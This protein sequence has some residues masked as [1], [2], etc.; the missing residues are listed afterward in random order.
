MDDFGGRTNS[1]GRLTSEI[2]SPTSVRLADLKSPGRE[3]APS[4]GRKRR[5]T[6][7]NS[8]TTAAAGVPERALDM[9]ATTPSIASSRGASYRSLDDDELEPETATLAP[10]K[11][12]ADM[13][14]RL[15]SQLSRHNVSVNTV[16]AE[17]HSV[18]QACAAH[19]FSPA[20]TSRTSPPYAPQRRLSRAGYRHF[21]LA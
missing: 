16:A 2:F 9:P 8:R 14:L 15:V 6:R 18:A 13:S 12:C 19:N 5:S 11:F 17:N 21:T 1:T 3:Q 10:Q 20:R 4:P 7:S